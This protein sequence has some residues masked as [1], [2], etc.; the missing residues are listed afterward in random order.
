[1]LG[2]STTSV[3]TTFP[4]LSRRARKVV[5]LF[6]VLTSVSW[7]GVDL[8]MGVLAFTGLTSDDPRT[9]ATVYTALELFCIPLLLTLGLLSLCSGLL[10]GLGTRFGM[11]RYWWVVVKLVVT[12]A[13]V[14]LVLVLLRPTL[15]EGAAASTVVDATLPDRLLD[16]RRGM[17]FPP[18]V[19]TTALVFLSWLAVYKPW[20]TTPRGR[21]F[22]RVPARGP[23]RTR[24]DA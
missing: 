8:V 16:V 23:E 2:T 11:L 17:V 1:M 24:V 3:P 12:V 15:L 20:G 10:L 5:L 21:R 18:V 4:R 6:H 14:V 7:V 22:L 13:L 9:L 19:S